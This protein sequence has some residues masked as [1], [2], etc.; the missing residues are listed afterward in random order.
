MKKRLL[1]MFLFVVVIAMTSTGI[2]QSPAAR[3]RTIVTTDGEVDDQ[4]SFIRLLLYS[5]EFNLEGL[6]YSSSQWHYKGD[7]KRTPFT[8]KM[9]STKERYGSRTNLRWPGT[10]WMQQLIGKY[11]SVYANLLQH[12]PGFPTAK[13]LNSIIRVGNINFEGDMSG[14]TEGSDFIKKSLLDDAPGPLYLQ[15]WGGTN[16]V[17]RALKSI[18]YSYKDK[19]DWKSVY[20]K[21]TKKAILYMVLDQ[22]ATYQDYIAKTWPAIRVMYNSDQFWCLAYPWPKFVPTPLQPSLK[23]PWFAENIKFNHGPLLASYYLWGDG[24]AIE[25]DPEHTHG[26]LREAKK[27]GLGQYDFISEGDSPA[28]FYLIDVGLRN[29]EDAAFGGWGGRM[30]PSPSN[31]H[32]REDGKHVTDYNPFTKKQDAA[33]P[34]TRWISD[35]QNDFAARADW[36][37][38]KYADANHPPLPRLKGPHSLKLKAGSKLQLEAGASD[39][40]GNEV[41]YRWWQYEEVDSYAGSIPIVHANTSQA[42]II[43]PADAKP[44]DTIHLILEATDNGSPALTRY[45]RLVITVE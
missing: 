22:D 8:S 11:D 15:I 44:G 9:K 24:T 6:I 39:P 28:F 45:Q 34:Q 35:L 32:R 1:S 40:D 25:N 16:T 33:Y 36:C 12:D 21:V 23:G 31:P 41:S 5:N 29:Q 37:V 4:D 3:A 10:T 17:A 7:G 38:K 42:S 14:D 30:V 18:E 2:A 43:V 26:D 27:F 19:A 13:Y 20:E